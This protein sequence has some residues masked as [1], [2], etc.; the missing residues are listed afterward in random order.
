M[1]PHPDRANEG[2]LK[3]NVRVGKVAGC[4]VGDDAMLDLTRMLERSFRD[5][6][7]V[8]REAL[9][10]APGVRVGVCWC[11]LGWLGGLGVGVAWVGCELELNF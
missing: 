1:A 11:T 7:A 8:D 3:F 4:A 5:S 2:M 6:G 10:V 9:C